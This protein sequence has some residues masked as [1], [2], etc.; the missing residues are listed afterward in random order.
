MYCHF[1]TPLPLY[2]LQCP[3]SPSQRTFIEGKSCAKGMRLRPIL[4]LNDEKNIN[5]F[6]SNK[7][8]KIIIVNKV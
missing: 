8:M 3:V 2:N 1:L 6:L 4:C 5:Y 7:D